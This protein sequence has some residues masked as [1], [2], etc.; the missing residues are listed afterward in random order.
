[1]KRFLLFTILC[2]LTFSVFAKHVERREAADI[3]GIVISAQQLKDISDATVFNNLYIFSDDHSFVIISADDSYR[4]IV[5]YS[6][7]SP[8]VFENMPDNI[9]YWLG[10]MNR[11]IQYAI[12]S[13]IIPAEDIQAEWSDLRRGMMPAPKTRTSVHPLLQMQWG[14]DAPYNNMCP[15]TTD[16]DGN[17]PV[18]CAATA[19]AQ[20]MKYWEWPRQGTGSH[21]YTATGYGTQTAN[22]GNTIYDWDNMPAIATTS[23][24]TAQQ[25]AVATLSYHCGVSLNM[26]YGDDGSGAYPSAVISALKTYFNYSNSISSASKNNYNLSQWINLLKTEINGG[27]P[28]HYS[29]WDTNDGGHS[30]VCDGYDENDKFHFNWGWNGSCDGYY[31]IGYL[32]PGQGG[33]G[34][35]SGCYNVSNYILIGIQPNAASIN[36]PSNLSASVDGK[37][38]TLTWDA[39]AGADHYKVYRNGFV[40]NSNVSETSFTDS[41]RPYGTFNYYVKSVK[42]D[43][44]YSH[45]SATASATVVFEI[46]TPTNLT[47]SVSG[48]NIDLSWIAPENE[49]A[50]LKYADSDPSGYSYGTG[51]ERAFYWGER[52]TPEQ[53]A[54]FAGMAIQSVEIYHKHVNEYTLHIYRVVDGNLIELA[55]K[56]YNTTNENSW[57]TITLSTPVAIDFTHDLIIA[58]HSDNI[59][60]PAPFAFQDYGANAEYYSLDGIGFGP[61][62]AGVSWLMK[63]NITDGTY[64]YNVYNDGVKIAENQ[65]NPNYS[66]TESNNGFHEYYV[67]TNY[68]GNESQ[69]SNSVFVPA[70]ATRQFLGTNSTDWSTASNWKNNETPSTS[71]LVWV[72]NN[73]E[74][75]ANTDINSLYINEGVTAT[76]NS[77]KTLNITDDVENLSGTDGLVLESGANLVTNAADLQA[78]VKRDINAAV[79]KDSWTGKWHFLSSP[80]E[81]QSVESFIEAASGGVIN[82]PNEHGQVGDITIEQG[83]GGYDFYLYHE[84]TMTW[85]N[86]KADP[87]EGQSLNLFFTEN[88]SHNF[89][90]GRG[91][92]VSFDNSSTMPFKGTVNQGETTINLTADGAKLTGFNLIGNPYPCSIDWDAKSGWSR[93][94]LGDNPYIWIYNDDL[95]QYGSYQLGNHGEGTNGVTNIIASCQ[96]F[97]VKALN[98]GDLIIND[99]VKTTATGVFRKEKNNKTISIKVEGRNGSDEVMVCQ[100]NERFNNAEKLYSR[101]EAVPSLY[102]KVDN[103]NYSIVNVAENGS[104]TIPMGF[105]CGTTGK[106]TISSNSNIELIDKLT[107][108]VTDLS[109]S[110]Y[111]FYGSN[112]DNHDRFLIRISNNSENDDFVYQNGN[113]LIVSGNGNVQVIDCLGRV[114][115][116]ETVNNGRINVSCL[117]TGVYVVRMNGDV[118]KIVIK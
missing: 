8:F 57:F 6:N 42:S 75:N 26:S 9:K 45:A 55:T 16:D 29:G 63:T 82:L 66:Y 27:R 47:A 77:E 113:E 76:V 89:V 2:S 36:T 91:Y 28:I 33:T 86:I 34:S 65:T 46:P 112:A 102:L 64:T 84:P 94:V 4:P 21:S 118:Q 22:F 83:V 68:F 10:S 37:N 44:N 7:D 116:N 17:C 24:S 14:Q 53:L 117:N 19:M 100:T 32:S 3:A 115:I 52:F 105:E 58:T 101:N 30:F 71:D 40:I 15:A 12:D 1:M 23:S 18:G 106:F 72:K 20:I 90:P 95:D 79:S 103:E 93:D 70:G 73:V 104:I 31:A 51:T 35:G 88:G 110:S 50:V 111:E 13:K 74:I 60:H 78:T 62:G 67:T 61:I 49:D 38:V 39:V 59:T 43:G 109:S 99:G 41:N 5:A 92:L 69:P 97:F 96:G 108:N 85:A 114:V 54:P 48:N 87:N 11:E 81:E 56:V 80:V 107:G 25:N 98:G